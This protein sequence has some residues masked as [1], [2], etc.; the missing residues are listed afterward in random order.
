VDARREM[1]GFL[2]SKARE[3]ASEEEGKKQLNE[4][5]AEQFKQS[6]IWDYFRGIAKK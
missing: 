4:R 5:L 2:N 6:D 1:D 3:A